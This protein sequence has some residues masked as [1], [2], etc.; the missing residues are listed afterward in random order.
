M[1]YCEL[2]ENNRRCC[3]TWAFDPFDF[4]AY[5]QQ[6][7][8]RD[9]R[10]APPESLRVAGCTTELDYEWPH[11]GRPLSSQTDLPDDAALHFGLCHASR[12]VWFYGAGK[13]WLPRN[14]EQRAEFCS[15]WS[16]DEA[17]APACRA[18]APDP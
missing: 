11:I 4:D 8:A 1:Q 6:L 13:G 3:N 9:S 5:L 15:D 16:H 2:H 17:F 14:D 12:V 7:R 10:F 18:E